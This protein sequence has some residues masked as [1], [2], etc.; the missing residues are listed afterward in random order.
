P[1]LGEA[2]LAAGA[3]DRRQ[4]RMQGEAVIGELVLARQLRGG[5]VADRQLQLQVELAFA[6]GAHRL[7]KAAGH[8]LYRRRVDEFEKV[9]GISVRLAADDDQ[10]L[11]RD[12]ARNTDAHVRELRAQQRAAAADD[13]HPVALEQQLAV[14]VVDERPA[15]GV[16]QHALR[17]E[18]H[19]SELQSRVDLVC[20]LLLEK[21]KTM[22]T[23]TTTLSATRTLP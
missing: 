18:E 11:A 4:L 16:V 8:A 23:P 14:D 1:G 15:V 6:D 7:G 9:A 3:L 19:T 17:S 12:Q 13:L 20:R 22:E 10:P 21:T 2:D 5:E